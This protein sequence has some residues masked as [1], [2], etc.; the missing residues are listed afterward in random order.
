MK[1]YYRHRGII[2]MELMVIAAT[3]SIVASITIPMIAKGRGKARRTVC[4][5]NQRQ[6]ACCFMMYVQDNDEIFP[7]SKNVWLKVDIDPDI[8]YC[9]EDNKNAI[10]YAYNNNLSS[11]NISKIQDPALKLF[12]VD[13][14]TIKGK[15]RTLNNTYY[16]PADVQYRHN[17]Q[18]MASYVDGHVAA[19]NKIAEKES[20]DK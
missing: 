14:E 17:N 6:I 7:K 2:A 13:G 20:W 3:F 9:P 8:L 19:V 10:S 11:I 4:I 16:S 18:A 12:T 1:K 15:K 5:S